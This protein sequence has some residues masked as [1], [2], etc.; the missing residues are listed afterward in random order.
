VHG[1]LF[2]LCLEVGLA[3]LEASLLL[4]LV[5]LL[6]PFLTSRPQ[7]RSALWLVLVLRLGL[8]WVPWPG[9]GV[10]VKVPP[11]QDIRLQE[12]VPVT[13][14]A[15]P[16][17]NGTGSPSRP[18]RPSLPWRDVVA[19]GWLLGVLA[20]GMRLAWANLRLWWAVRQGRVLTRQPILDLLERCKADLGIRTPLVIILTDRV[21]G[22]ALFGLLRP[23]L[24]LSPAV[25]DTLSE[26]G[27]RHVLLHEL[28][29]LQ[30]LDLLWAWLAAALQVIHWFNPLLWWAFRQMRADREVAC[31]AL[32]LRVLPPSEVAAYGRTLLGLQETLRPSAPLPSL[33]GIG[34]DATHFSRRILMISRFKPG[35]RW[36]AASLALVGLTAALFG[37][38]LVA[39][40]VMPKRLAQPIRDNVR[41]P[42]QTDPEV[43]G[44]WRA[45]DFVKRVEDFVPGKPRVK[46]SELYLKTMFFRPDGT[47]NWAFTWTKGLV[48]HDGDETASRYLIRQ[49]DGRTLL[50]MEWKSG[51]YTLYGMTPQWY[52]LEKDP[53]LADVRS[54]R[55][56]N[57]DVP[58]ADDPA[59]VGTWTW[60]DLVEKEEDFKPGQK[61]FQGRF[62]L[63][64]LVV[65]PGGKTQGPWSWTRGLLIHPGDRTAAAYRIREMEGRTYLMWEFKNGDYIFR[66]AKPHWIVMTR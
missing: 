2:V 57:I 15:A 5:L 36:G 62:M 45:V 53:T 13:A 49:A 59:L 66:G 29:H 64:N 24:L 23:R 28:A 20:F 19:V 11:V 33:A 32:A 60:A 37:V 7:V 35:P 30:R 22:P 3:A 1:S 51:D 43:L 34:E 44:G 61:A 40:E 9:I 21:P 56:D 63:P 58:F 48:L 27:L 4:G 52:V 12:V 10:P 39:Q 42:F 38:H 47:T 8:A 6:R 16:V 55:T 26:E 31:D 54:R 50:F 17:A 46:A 14:D 41:V 65:L 25:L 18:Q